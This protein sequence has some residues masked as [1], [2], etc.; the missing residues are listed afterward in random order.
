MFK[1][2]LEARK[3]ARLTEH[4]ARFEVKGGIQQRKGKRANWHHGAQAGGYFFDVYDKHVDK[5]Y[6]IENI[7]DYLA[8]GRLKRGEE[9]Q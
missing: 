9:K 1:T 2:E 5:T 3:A 4:M 6:R 8:L 7:E